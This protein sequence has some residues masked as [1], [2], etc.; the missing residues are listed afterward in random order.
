MLRT[1]AGF[2]NHP[3]QVVDLN[4]LNGV[5]GE[6]GILHSYF[7]TLTPFTEIVSTAHILRLFKMGVV[8]CQQGL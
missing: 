2:T 1:I 4:Q 7:L 3:P 6:I 8:Q 5:L